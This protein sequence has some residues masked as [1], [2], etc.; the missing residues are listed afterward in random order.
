MTT[1]CPSASLIKLNDSCI[2]ICLLQNIFSPSMKLA[3]AR[4]APPLQ[5]GK[6]ML[7]RFSQLV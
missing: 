2:N 7:Q 6:K 5:I 3:F 4:T 1:V